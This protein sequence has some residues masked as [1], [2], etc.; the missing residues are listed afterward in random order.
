MSA[1]LKSLREGV[2]EF[3]QAGSDVKSA[4][5]IRGSEL[6]SADLREALASD[7]RSGRITPS[8][9][10][11]QLEPN[12]FNQ[13]AFSIFR[14]IQ[15]PSTDPQRKKE[16]MKTFGEMMTFMKAFAEAGRSAKDSGGKEK[17]DW[18][19]IQKKLIDGIPLTTG[20]LN[21]YDFKLTNAASA[22]KSD[23]GAF[24]TI[25]DKMLARARAGSGKA[26]PTKTTPTGERGKVSKGKSRIS[27][28]MS[29][30]GIK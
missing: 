3:V 8:A 11:K 26:T 4:E 29:S 12:G 25:K 10:Q 9:A 27:S 21:F 7:V 20:E 1:G 5:T 14:Q 6:G 15:D 18:E 17:S 2:G 16:L 23:I 30:A 28:T 22:S 24:T 19:M 13:M